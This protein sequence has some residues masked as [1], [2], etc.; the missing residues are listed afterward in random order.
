MDYNLQWLMLMLECLVLGAIAFDFKVDVISEK[1]K[2]VKP[3]KIVRF[4][5]PNVY[6]LRKQCLEK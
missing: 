2:I 3:K 1:K 6:R 4:H 5:N